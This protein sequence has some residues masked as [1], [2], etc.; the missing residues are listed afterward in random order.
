VVGGGVGQ[1]VDL[2]D[3]LDVVPDIMAL[4][5][6]PGG[7]VGVCDAF[8][9]GEVEEEAG[10]GFLGEAGKDGGCAAWMV[11]VS[12]VCVGSVC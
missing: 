6:I 2:S 4:C 11:D 10:G 7:G 9:A 1:V 3:M 8:G 12:G 5:P